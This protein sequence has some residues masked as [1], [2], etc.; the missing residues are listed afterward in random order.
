M[1]IFLK[2]D[3][4]SKIPAIMLGAKMPDV[5]AMAKKL[6]PLLADVEMKS[7]AFAVNCCY[8]SMI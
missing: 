2:E 8:L 1:L 4:Y 3:V 7:A 6:L 5:L